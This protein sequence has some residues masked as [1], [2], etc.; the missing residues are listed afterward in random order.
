[1][2]SLNNVFKL[3]D[4]I[5]PEPIIIKDLSEKISINEKELIKILLNFQKTG[6][7]SILEVKIFDEK[8]EEVLS[9]EDINYAYISQY[10]VQI[11]NELSELIKIISF[12]FEERKVLYHLFKNAEDEFIKNEREIILKAFN[13]EK[14]FIKTSIKDNDYIV[15]PRKTMNFNNDLFMPLYQYMKNKVTIE[16]FLLNEVILYN[17]SPQWIVYEEEY[18]EWYL[19]YIHKRTKKKIKLSN[20]K[21]LRVFKNGN[22]VTLHETKDNNRIRGLQ[23]N[24]TRVMVRVYRE[25]NAV[26][27]F[28]EYYHKKTRINKDIKEEFID[29]TLE[30]EDESIFLRF[31]RSL[32]PSALI[33]EP[34]RLREKVISKLDVW[35]EVI[36]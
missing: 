28:N 9:E 27:I 36:K 26:E 7:D 25:R 33:L 30:V 21:S 35:E 18:N 12:S 3:L 31:I 14:K 16:I 20:I 4:Y 2:L 13:E 34:I 1:M 24:N 32:T 17:V 5:V 23:K 10:E 11:D 29:Y 8:N 19:I 22:Y 6:A 15:F